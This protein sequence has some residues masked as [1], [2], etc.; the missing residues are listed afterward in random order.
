MLFLSAG[1]VIDAQHH[2]HDIFKMGGLKTRLPFAYWTFLIGAAS[3]SALPL[4]TAGFFSKDAIIWSSYTSS[5][6][7][8]WLWLGALLGALITAAYSFRVLYLVF[9]GE[10]KIEVTKRPGALMKLS[11]AIL[12]FF[13]IAAGYIGWPEIL[14]KFNPFGELLSS[15]L[16]ALPASTARSSHAAETTL[17]MISAILGFAGIVLAYVYFKKR[18][19]SEAVARSRVARAVHQFFYTGWGS[20]G[21]MTLSSSVHSRQ[22]PLQTAAISSTVSS[23]AW[24]PPPA[25]LTAFPPPRPAASATTPPGWCWEQ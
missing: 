13:S 4:V 21:S 3:L 20:I 16:P 12:A 14:G 10:Q 2:E 24:H 7:N 19:W 15:T 22:S 8:T 17:L 5:L 11:L 25:I 23:R 18:N 9:H 6:G 1:V